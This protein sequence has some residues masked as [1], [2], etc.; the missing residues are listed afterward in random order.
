VNTSTLTT[1]PGILR[2]FVKPAAFIAAN[3]GAL[4]G[5][6]SVVGLF[7]ALAG[8]A[9]VLTNLPEHADEAFSQSLRHVRCT[10]RRDWPLSVLTWA[11]VLGVAFNV[12]FLS[13]QTSSTRVFLTGL[14][15]P[16]TWLLVSYLSAAMVV[17]RDP[18]R[19][20]GE[21]LHRAM[22]LIFTH[23]IRALLAPSLVALL[24]PVW[25]LAPLTIACG[26]SLPPFL[27]TVLWVGRDRMDP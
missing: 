16:A 24:V 2:F 4:L 27:V 15:L 10:G 9:R 23:P 6:V 19:A 1:A 13:Q 18:D 14:V 8:A 21:V 11:V 22:V 3:W 20:R 26:F 5:V 25:A 17:A 12:A 7:P